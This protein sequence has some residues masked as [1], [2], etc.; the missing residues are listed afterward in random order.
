MDEFEMAC[1]MSLASYHEEQQLKLI[2]ASSNL[3]SN[4]TDR[5]PVNDCGDIAFSKI[6]AAIY[7]EQFVGSVRNIL[8]SSW[9]D[10]NGSVVNT[11]LY[12]IGE[13]QQLPVD[14]I[15]RLLSIY[16]IE[17]VYIR[18][19]KIEK[20]IGQENFVHGIG[21]VHTVAID[22]ADTATIKAGGDTLL[23]GHYE[24]V[25]YTFVDGELRYHNL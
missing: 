20:R 22:Y 2:L 16:L 7:G 11:E 24:A 6:F 5:K 8:A 23:A 19:N 25:R 12:G 13:G 15:D 1:Q 10:I 14:A 3:D 18:K 21:I 9:N 4:T 17:I